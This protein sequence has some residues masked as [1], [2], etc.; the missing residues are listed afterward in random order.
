MLSE[1]PVDVMLSDIRMPG[2]DGIEA[3]RHLAA[4]GLPVGAV[5]WHMVSPS[6]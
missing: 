1:R 6:S 3:A 5:A 4:A 2:M